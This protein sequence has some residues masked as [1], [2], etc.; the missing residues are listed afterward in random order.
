MENLDSFHFEMDLLAKMESEGLSLDIPITF[1]GDFQAPDRVKGIVNATFFGFSVEMETIAIGDTT[2]QQNPLSGQWEVSTEPATPFGGPQD[3]LSDELFAVEDLELVGAETLDGTPVYIL[4]GVVPPEAFD[5]E[6]GEFS[7]Q[8]WIGRGDLYLRQMKLEGEA[9][10]D[11]GFL[12]EEA[13]GGKASLTMT[14][15]LSGFDEPVTIEPPE[16]VVLPTPP[17]PPPLS[18]P[19][20]T[21]SLTPTVIPVGPTPTPGSAASMPPVMV[22]PTKPGQHVPEGQPVDYPMSPPLFGD[23][24]ASTASCGFY[25]EEIPNER[26]VHNLEHGNV[27]ISYNLPDPADVQG[28]R[29]ALEGI[30]GFDQWGIARPYPD[31]A[32]GNLAVTAWGTLMKLDSVNEQAIANFFAKYS[33]E[34]SNAP[35]VIPCA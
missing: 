12:G 15:T 34:G 35:E 22:V 10:L 11:G 8:M 20:P 17:P 31:L 16:T 2:Y 27:V 19:E 7:V 23:H 9:P 26:I 29:A 32:E 13:A 14:F 1:S 18:S 5:E 21:R 6:E 24:W 25:E 4:V 33:A 28:L 3:L 30:D